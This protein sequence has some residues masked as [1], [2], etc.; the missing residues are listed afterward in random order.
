MH[1]RN[2]IEAAFGGRAF[3]RPLFHSHPGGLRFALSDGCSPIRRFVV[4]LQKSQMICDEI[5]PIGGSLVVCLQVHAE[6]SHFAHR[7]HIRE[8]LEADIDIPPERS[9]WCSPAPTER[10]L[11]DGGDG[12]LIHLAFAAPLSLLPHFLW[13]SMAVDCG[14]IRPRTSCNIYLFNLQERL[15]VWPY[16]DRGMDV[17]GPNHLRLSALFHKYRAHL[18]EYELPAML[19]TFEPHIECSS[20]RPLEAT[21]PKR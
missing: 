3:A 12:W 17:V 7:K 18:N 11:E 6:R 1:L 9:I 21:E 19:K 10:E 16:D 15:L 4:A 2:A 8:M 5:F 20:K 14:S 13:C